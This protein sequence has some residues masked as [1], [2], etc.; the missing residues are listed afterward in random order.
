MRYVVS[1]NRINNIDITPIC[2]FD[3]LIILKKNVLE[4]GKRN[5]IKKL[6]RTESSNWCKFNIIKRN[7]K[8][9]M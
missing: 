3:T 1:K 6:N 5:Q 4:N 9:N 8:M 2:T 7:K